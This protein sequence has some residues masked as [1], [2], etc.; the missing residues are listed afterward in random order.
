MWVFTRQGVS[1]KKILLSCI[2]GNVG[3]R[4]FD[5]IVCTVYIVITLHDW[6]PPM[7]LLLLLSASDWHLWTSWTAVSMRSKLC[8][9]PL[10]SVSASAPLL[11]ITTSLP[12]FPPRWVC[13]LECVCL[14]RCV[15]WCG[16]SVY[17]SV[18]AS[19][20]GSWL[21]ISGFLPSQMGNWKNATVLFLHSNKLES[22]P[23]E[24]GDMQ[25]LKVINLSNNKWVW[26]DGIPAKSRSSL[27]AKLI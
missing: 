15:K 14:Q 11:Q 27:R 5:T 3:S 12:S 20:I 9:L 26:T 8:L 6:S 23:E 7:F 1:N 4:V 18:T 17:S 10:A 22:L 16:M 2:I 19:L 13:T 24:M 25:K 21:W